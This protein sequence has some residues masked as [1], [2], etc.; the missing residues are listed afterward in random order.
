VEVPTFEK[1][2]ANVSIYT[3]LEP[4]AQCTG[5]MALAGIKEII[6]VQPDD[7]TMRVSQVLY[8]LKPY[9]KAPKPIIGRLCGGTDYGKL[10]SD[11]YE[12]FKK[13][14]FSGTP[15]WVDAADP[16]NKDTT[17]SLTSFLCT[18]AA[19]DIIGRATSALPPP[20][21][22][23]YT[24]S[25]EPAQEPIATGMFTNQEVRDEVVNFLS[26]ASRLGHRGTAH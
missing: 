25:L 14:V 8:R 11:A 21:Y 1:M 6:Y 15:V 19:F 24:R 23:T 13:Q 12:V 20:H 7:G 5:I 3:T 2:F 4:C 10:L 22:E 16:T 17:P 9:G 26:Y 18:D